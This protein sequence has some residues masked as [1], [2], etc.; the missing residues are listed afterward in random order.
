MDDMQHICHALGRMVY[1]TLKVYKSR[2]LL[3]DTVLIALC[4]R[5]HKFFLVSMSFADIHIITDTNHISH[6]G[7]HICCFAY[8]LAVSNLRFLFVQVLYFKA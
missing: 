1:I 6:E 2:T 3:Q 5:I 4:N 8:S 7:N